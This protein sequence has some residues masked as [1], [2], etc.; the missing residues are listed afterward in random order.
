[1]NEIENT[2]KTQG[3]EKTLE[4]AKL[5]MKLARKITKEMNKGESTNENG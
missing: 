1:M 4:L 5:A 2:I 3:I